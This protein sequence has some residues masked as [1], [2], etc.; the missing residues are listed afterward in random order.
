MSQLSSENLS[1]TYRKRGQ[2][3]TALNDVSL[4]VDPGEFLV[5][6]GP[7]GS[8]KSTLLYALGG[9]LHPTSGTVTFDGASLYDLTQQQ[10]ATW[11]AA[12]V[13]FV[14]QM[15]HLVPYLSALENVLLSRRDSSVL[16]EAESVLDMLGMAAR[17][18]HRPGELSA[19]E[20]QR[21]AVA[22]AMM[23]PPRVI[24]ADEPTGNLDGENAHIV[25]DAL[26]NFRQHG[27]AVVF[28][29]HGGASES[30]ATRTIQLRDGRIDV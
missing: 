28:V 11:R 17:R 5:V 9:M 21:V 2:T 4:S 27:G 23:G 25:C 20:R 30:F 29:T 15:F 3:V 1:K 26:D 22:R 16:D 10:R 6:R 7:S 14:F 19:G 24:L 12:H 8:G 18:H 13:G